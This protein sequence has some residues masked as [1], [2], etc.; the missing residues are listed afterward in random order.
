M[1]AQTYRTMLLLVSVCICTTSVAQPPALPTP[2]PEHEWLQK[3]E[4]KWSSVSKGNLGPDQPKIESKGTVTSQAVGGFWIVNR[5][6]FEVMGSSV[7]GVQTL[8][9]DSAKGKFTGSWIDSGSDHAWTYEG[10]LNADKTKLTL[11]TE[12]PN[13]LD[14][15]KMSKFRDAYEFKSADEVVATSAIQLEDGAWMVF[16]KGTMTRIKEQ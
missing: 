8:G 14:P 11:N 15:T 10:S 1:I 9:F 16:M 6:E 4:G 13:L 5:F 12:G 7:A 2:T 3:F